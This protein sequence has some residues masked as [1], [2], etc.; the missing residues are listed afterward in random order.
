[1]IKNKDMSIYSIKM[2][3]KYFKEQRDNS[4]SQERWSHYNNEVERM[5]RKLYE[6]E[7]GKE[8]EE[9]ESRNN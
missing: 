6:L 9:Y 3:I 1:M 7:V 8:L 5:E 4:K 2:G